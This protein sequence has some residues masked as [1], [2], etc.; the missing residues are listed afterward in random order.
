[1]GEPCPADEAGELFK[2][3]HDRIYRYVLRLMRNPGEAEDLTQDIFCRAYCRRDSLRDQQALV[4]WLYRIA[5]RV[6]LDRLRQHKPE[7]SLEGGTDSNP[8][9]AAICPH[10]SALE[11]AERNETSECVQRCLQFLPDGYRAVIILCEIYS[12]TAAQMATVLGENLTTVKMR[13]HRA[14]RMLKRVMECGCAV[15]NDC[16]GV[17]VCQPKSQ[18]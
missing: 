7:F 5:T 10:P 13:L 15:S 6:C 9:A 12:L 8:A 4:A 1:M 14:R 2:Q 17:P 16:H 11:I 3:Y 18:K